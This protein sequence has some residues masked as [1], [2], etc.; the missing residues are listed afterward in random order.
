MV[1]AVRIAVLGV[2]LPLTRP[3][4][5]SYPYSYPSAVTSGNP[6][7][8]AAPSSPLSSLGTFAPYPQ[9]VALS[10]VAIFTNG[11]STISAAVLGTSILCCRRHATFPATSAGASLRSSDTRL[12]PPPLIRFARA[13]LTYLG[14]GLT[15]NFLGGQLSEDTIHAREKVQS[16][17]PGLKDSMAA[18]EVRAAWQ[19]SFRPLTTTHEDAIRKHSKMGHCP[20]VSAPPPPATPSAGAPTPARPLSVSQ[21]VETRNARPCFIAPRVTPRKD[22]ASPFPVGGN[23]MPHPMEVNVRVS[24][25]SC[26]APP[27]GSTH[28][29][30]GGGGGGGGGG[31]GGVTAEASVMSDGLG[32]SLTLEEGRGGSERERKRWRARGDG[33]G[34][35][36]CAGALGAEAVCAGEQQPQQQQQQQQQPQQDGVNVPTPVAGGSTHVSLQASI[37]GTKRVGAGA[38]DASTC[39]MPSPGTRATTAFAFTDWRLSDDMKNDSHGAASAGFPEKALRQQEMLQPTTTK[40]GK[41]S[42]VFADDDMECELLAREHT[43]MWKTTTMTPIKMKRKGKHMMGEVETEMIGFHKE[44]LFDD[45]GS[46][47]TVCDDESSRKREPLTMTD[48]E[49]TADCFPD[50]ATKGESESASWRHGSSDWSSP[51]KDHDA[52]AMTWTEEDLYVD[53]GG[54]LLQPATGRLPSSTVTTDSPMDESPPVMLGHAYVRVSG[55]GNSSVDGLSSSYYTS[56]KDSSQHKTRFASTSGN[57]SRT[58]DRGAGTSRSARHADGAVLLGE[59]LCRSQTRAREAEFVAE[60]VLIENQRLRQFV[61]REAS[62]SYTHRL[63][64]NILEVENDSLKMRSCCGREGA[65]GLPI[66]GY[67]KEHAANNSSSGRGGGG[68]ALINKSHGPGL[69]KQNRKGE[70]NMTRAKDTPCDEGEVGGKQEA[71][72]GWGGQEGTVPNESGS[73]WVADVL[74]VSLALATIGICTSVN[75]FDQQRARSA[76]DVMLLLPG[77]CVLETANATSYWDRSVGMGWVLYLER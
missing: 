65:G 68:A 11:Y 43:D 14:P 4:L 56:K 67:T 24:V 39:C 48:D 8:I 64:V 49:S 22:F 1:E 40:A 3:I 47:T 60:A 62:R 57:G 54:N 10:V 2:R 76:G 37:V 19:R 27:G 35:A 38:Y 29:K 18:A 26:S 61:F 42:S 23:G 45:V 33:L 70:D 31:K 75:L 20:I 6:A 52:D 51:A 32:V 58:T 53:D 21:Q 25:S 63:W 74:T 7:V 66:A 28:V 77:E 59:A 72:G 9:G 34:V 5:T 16:T 71:K 41:N 46:V 12:Q 30:K 15:A 13:V 17:S 73:G 50:I 69:R 36:I 55:S 44:S